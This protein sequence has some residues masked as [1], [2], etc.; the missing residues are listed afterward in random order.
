M[1]KSVNAGAQRDAAKPTGEIGLGELE[2]HLG[3]FVR[4][5]QH[6]IFRDVNAALAAGRANDELVDYENAWRSS[7]VGEDLFKVRN[8]KPLW[9][10]FGT[11]LGVI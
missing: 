3:Y 10:K 8:V 9:S 1:S 11:V 6:W 7:P 4:R 2:N 5:L